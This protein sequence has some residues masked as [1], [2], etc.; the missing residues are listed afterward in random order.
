MAPTAPP[1]PSPPRPTPKPEPQETEP[2]PKKAEPAETAK[3]I[4]RPAEK[5][6]AELA[7]SAVDRPSSQKAAPA[8]PDQ[9][10]PKIDDLLDLPQSTASRITG[11]ERH[12]RRPDVA[13]GDAIWL[14]TEKDLLISFFQRFK[15]NIYG[16]WNYPI[17]AA[18]RGEQ[19]TTLLRITV[20]RDGSV[21]SVKLEESSGSN[22]L[23]REAIRAVWTGASYGPLPR[24]YEEETLTIFAFFQYT[25]GGRPFV[26]GGR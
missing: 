6:E 23:D 18:E 24:A 9:P 1:A 10:L 17:K 13:E 16:V 15:A 7:P 14:D 20:R 8:A 22:T 2:K 5:H 4:E 12:K 26:H 3:P 21:E 11:E 25:L 19:G